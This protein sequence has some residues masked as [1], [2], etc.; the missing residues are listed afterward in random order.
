MSSTNA[1]PSPFA[2]LFTLNRQQ[3]LWK[4]AIVAWPAIALCLCY[5]QY[6]GRMLP[7]L[8]AAGG[9][10]TVGMGAMQRFTRFSLAPMLLACIG[11]MFSAWAGSMLGDS[12]PALI[13]ASAVWAALGGI[14]SLWGPGLTWICQ[15]ST[16]AWFVAGS[17]PGPQQALHRALMV[18]VGG[19]VQIG[20]LGLLILLVPALRPADTSSTAIDTTHPVA[21][22]T[23]LRS[24][25]SAVLAMLA[26][27]AIGIPHSY[28]APMTALVVLKPSLNDEFHSVLQRCIGTVA[29]AFIASLAVYLLH[30]GIGT[31]IFLTC[32]FAT[33]AFSLN[34]VSYLFF[35]AGLTAYIVFMLSIAHTPEL[36]LLAQRSAATL[37]GC[38]VALA[39]DYFLKQCGIDASRRSQRPETPAP[40]PVIAAE[41][42]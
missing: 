22:A 15:Q 42:R 25:L 31:L 11:M 38:A 24:A 20:L 18:G 6:T 4:T 7:F 36:G 28:W 8:V 34:R 5:G 17:F 41:R 14:A 32:V 23:A 13:V 35:S 30:P 10:F 29:G 19:V 16:I 40:A 27:H 2:D 21:F 1:T 9:A 33:V 37:L 39:T 26:A 12:M 3:W